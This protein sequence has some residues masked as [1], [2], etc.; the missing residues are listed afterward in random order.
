MTVVMPTVIELPRR[1]EP[2]TTDRFIATG[3]D[4]HAAVRDSRPRMSAPTRVCRGGPIAE[5]T[6]VEMV[7][8]SYQRRT[9]SA[10]MRMSVSG[11]R[12]FARRRRLLRRML[13]R[14]G[15]LAM[16]GIGI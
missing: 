4:A 11:R 6:R 5:P 8:L 9:D 15:V 12:H 10:L 2:V 7:A 1:L 16:P 13:R 14:P 3:A